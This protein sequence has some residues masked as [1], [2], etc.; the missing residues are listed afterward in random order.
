MG[1]AYHLE[2]LRWRTYFLET[3]YVSLAKQLSARP[4]HSLLSGELGSFEGEAP[5]ESTP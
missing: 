4:A 2:A 1:V 3:S 5:K